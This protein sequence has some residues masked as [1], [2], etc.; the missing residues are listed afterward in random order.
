MQTLRWKT[1]AIIFFLILYGCFSGPPPIKNI[2]NSPA[3]GVS[4]GP[5]IEI[6]KMQPKRYTWAIDQKGNAHFI[7]EISDPKEL[8]YVVVGKDG[9]LEKSILNKLKDIPWYTLNKK[10][11]MSSA[12]DYSGNLHLLRD[13]EHFVYKDKMWE[14]QPAI[15]CRQFAKGYKDL[16]CGYVAGG[17]EFDSP[18]RLD[19]YIIAV[20][21]GGLIWPWYSYPDK[22]VIVKKN[23]DGWFKPAVVDS[24]TK[25]DVEMFSLAADEKGNLY[26]GY[27]RK[28]RNP[29]GPEFRG[30]SL[31]Y[32]KKELTETISK[33][34]LEESLKDRI[35][36]V[37]GESMK[38]SDDDFL[39]QN[40]LPTAPIVA[41]DP[42]SGTAMFASVQPRKLYLIKEGKF[43]TALNL[44]L[45]DR[46]QVVPVAA[47]NGQ[48]HVIIV[49]ITGV[50]H[51]EYYYL[52]CGE[53]GCSA[54]VLH[55]ED[56]GF[57]VISDGKG[58]AL[59]V[60][61]NKDKPFIVKWIKINN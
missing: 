31:V 56:T 47:G 25:Q 54:P 45:S 11:Y 46:T 34:P 20:Y 28:R 26:A 16:I 48:F 8:Q 24:D 58:N 13:G 61:R 12:F 50:G 2:P 53:T 60:M 49:G 33:Y 15:P 29:L 3:A 18:G 14:E 9:I 38:G 32:L 36:T 40:M 42:M 57:G 37:S 17:S 10:N 59:L 35:V 51:F 21:G 7:I 30:L 19:W 27:T 23:D 1:L 6:M 4:F 41:V 39:P 52:I 43:K 5:E 55:S 44:E 22:L